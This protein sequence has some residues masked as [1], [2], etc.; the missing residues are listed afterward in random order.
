MSPLGRHKKKCVRTVCEK[1][2]R[3]RKE[4]KEERKGGRQG[5]GGETRGCVWRLTD[6]DDVVVCLVRRLTASRA[7]VIPSE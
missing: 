3:R 2:E 1:E 5:E 7:H 4:E 6:H